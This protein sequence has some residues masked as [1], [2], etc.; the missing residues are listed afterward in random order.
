MKLRIFVIVMLATCGAPVPAF[1]QG[2]VLEG[3]ILPMDYDGEGGR[4]YRVYG[5]YG[6][7]T[8]DM[9]SDKK[10]RARLVSR[11]RHRAAAPAA[12]RH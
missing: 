1:A 3:N 9:P 12:G 4:H 11:S 7:Y 6:D 8:P 5:Y 10:G 2:H